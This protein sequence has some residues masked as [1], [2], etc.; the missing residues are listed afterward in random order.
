MHTPTTTVEHLPSVQ[1]HVETTVERVS[2]LLG[3]G[4]THPFESSRILTTP[5]PQPLHAER[6]LTDWG[7]PSNC[8]V[9]H[10][11]HEGNSEHATVGA[12]SDQTDRHVYVSGGS[13]KRVC[14]ELT[15]SSSVP[16]P[17]AV[18]PI[19]TL[20]RPSSFFSATH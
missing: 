3:L 2:G 18:L 13:A 8:G 19:C 20:Y 16:S 11:T 17:L 15:V 5:P 12:R 10:G 7:R 14:S 6:S 4:E 9:K 1:P